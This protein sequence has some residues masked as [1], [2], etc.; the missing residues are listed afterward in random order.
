MEALNLPKKRK[1]AGRSKGGKGRSK[2]VQCS[3]CGKTVPRDKAKRK[4]SYVSFV[5]PQLA[6]DLR[7]QGAFIPR[8]STVKY[9]CI[10]CAVH[11]GIVKI[12]SKDDRRGQSLY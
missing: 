3:M 6:K 11:R 12:R 1:S 5:D 9:Y 4:E 2:S 8:Q 7:K 10:N